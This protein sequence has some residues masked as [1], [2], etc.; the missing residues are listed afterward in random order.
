MQADGH[1]D[2]HV[3]GDVDGRASSTVLWG[4]DHEVFAE[5]ATTG[6]PDGVGGALSRGRFPKQYEHVDPNEDAVLLA[7]RRGVLLLAVADGHNG[8]DA[9]EAALEGVLSAFNGDWEPPRAATS[10]LAGL[11]TRAQPHALEA[12]AAAARTAVAER[13][14]R[15]DDPA[16]R[17]SRTALSL[18][19]VVGDGMHVLTFGDTA[20]FLV[21]GRRVRRL[22]SSGSFLGARTELPPST[23]LR[24]RGDDRVVVASD[25]CTDFL[26]RG[27]DDALLAA[28]AL[29]DPVRAARGL[30]QAAGDAG[31]GD[32]VAVVVA[33]HPTG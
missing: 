6:L 16:R 13:L 12:L 7:Q 27:L 33:R 3:D 18:A 2:G 15:V 31:A 5:I 8:V 4:R 21:R 17:A 10:R 28:A 1:A 14:R 19:V 20:V 32:N 29:D 30:V 11:V 23:T 25:G 9:G 22:G 24:L 26:G